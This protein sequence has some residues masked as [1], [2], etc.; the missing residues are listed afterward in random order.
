[1]NPAM[2]LPGRMTTTG[3]GRSP[4][5]PAA[6]ALAATP[7]VDLFRELQLRSGLESRPQD[8]T[9]SGASAD[10]RTRHILRRRL[11][12]SLR[13]F[14]ETGGR[15]T[16]CFSHNPP[17]AS[18]LGESAGAVNHK[19]SNSFVVNPPQSLPAPSAFS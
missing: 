15:N 13:E 16:L 19:L 14:A 17:F 12:R 3:C 10:K 7:S 2:I 9:H 5:I 8:V 1:M 4:E 11:H 18:L 6:F